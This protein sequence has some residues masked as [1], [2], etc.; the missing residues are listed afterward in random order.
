VITKVMLE[1]DIIL[2]PAGMGILCLL[3]HP[4]S[5]FSSRDVIPIL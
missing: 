1:Y 3:C 2:Y 4:V 5:D